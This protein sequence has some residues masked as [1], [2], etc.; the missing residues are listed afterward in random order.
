MSGKPVQR[1]AKHG[2]VVFTNNYSITADPLL[3]D[4]AK[5]NTV[6]HSRLWEMAFLSTLPSNITHKHRK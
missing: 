1:A 6:E 3:L 2:V 4:I 5:K